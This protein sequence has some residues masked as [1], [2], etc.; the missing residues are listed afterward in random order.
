MREAITFV[1]VVND[2][3]E[4]DHNLLASPVR[5]DSAHEWI[6]IDNV[7]NRL[8]DS[9]TPLYC[10][11]LECAT[12][13]LVFFFHQDVYL[14]DAW[15]EGMYAALYDLEASDPNWGVVGAVGVVG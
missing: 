8:A 9:I 3:A 1:T 5:A 12:H 15:E 4:L 11:A 10:D 13:D 7:S 2:F 6:L 14:P